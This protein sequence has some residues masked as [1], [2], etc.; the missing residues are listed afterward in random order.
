MIAVT[1]IWIWVQKLG[2]IQQGVAGK[3]DVLIMNAYEARIWFWTIATDSV[4]E[5]FGQ[6]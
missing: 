3:V 2:G 4:C 6:L 5:S 1:P